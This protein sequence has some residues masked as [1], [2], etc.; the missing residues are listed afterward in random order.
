M[1][2]ITKKKVAAYIKAVAKANSV[3]DATEKFT[4][5]A[6]A[7]QKIVA[8]IR[9][10]NWFL[11][12]INVI[13]VSNQSGEAL[14]LGVSG[15]LASRTDTK[16]PSKERTTKAAY[17]LNAMP[18]KC[19]QTNFDTHIRYDQLDAFAHLKNFNKIITQQTR[20][21][22]DFNKIEV[23]FYGKTAAAT[24]DPVTNV[25]GED[26]NTGWIQALREH[27]PTAILSEGATANILKIGQ[28][29]DIENL[30]LLVLNLRTLL[31]DACANAPDLVTIVGTDLLA[32]EK[33]K[34]YAAN[35]N[36]PS[37]KSKIEDI[38]VI[39]TFGGLPAFSVPGF[40]AR[41]AMVTSFKNLS[42]YI[43]EGSIRRSVGVKNDR[44]DQLENFESMNLAY[45]IEQLDKAAA[46]EFD[47]VQLYVNGTW[48]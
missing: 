3:D 42:L 19:M 8:A 20:E 2:D 22:I 1:K 45:V 12:R 14:G 21:Q 41:G 24:T 39:G 28:G 16:N 47:N 37:E 38:Q 17:A 4:V 13:S 35:G 34:F 31:S 6:T 11:S 29:G 46:V 18:Y 33:A 15:M 10:S 25:H 40:P 5:N 9:E 27:K 44:R 7:T 36:T 43:Q 30:D 48:V 23:G 32:Y 26:V